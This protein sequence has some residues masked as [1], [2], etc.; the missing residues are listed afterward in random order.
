MSDG[1]KFGCIGKLRSQFDGCA[2]RQAG[3]ALDG[4]RLR[5]LLRGGAQ[6]RGVHG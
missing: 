6:K 1:V 5:L 2:L 3:E 4:Y